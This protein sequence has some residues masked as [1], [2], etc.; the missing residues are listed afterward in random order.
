MLIAEVV[1]TKMAYKSNQKDENGNYLPIGSIQIR[2]G[3]SDT[4]LGQVRN[5]YARPAIFNKRIPL[6]GLKRIRK[7][8]S[9]LV[10]DSDIEHVSSMLEGIFFPIPI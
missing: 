3:G 8:Q 2:M 5:V 10:A 4:S 9:S 7:P 1:E 6:I